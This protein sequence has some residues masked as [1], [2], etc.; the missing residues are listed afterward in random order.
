MKKYIKYITSLLV[1]VLVGLFLFRKGLPIHNIRSVL[2]QARWEWL[3]LALVWQ[4][5]AY[6]AVTTLNKIILQHYGADVPWSKQYVIQLAM[7][8]I[9]AAVPSATISGAVLRIRLLKPHGVSA[10]VATVSTI[11][12]MVLITASIILLAIPVFVVVAVGGLQGRNILSQ[13][14]HLLLT[15]AFSIGVML[16]LW[17]TGRFNRGARWMLA[18]VSRVWD[19]RILPRWRRQLGHWSSQTIINRTRHLGSE[20]VTLIK[21]N[22]YAIG[23][24]LFARSAFEALGLMMCFYALGQ[25]I[26]FF[27][28]LL[29]Y[30]LTIAINALGSVPGG[31][32]LAEVSL[33]VLYTQFGIPPETAVVIALA[34]RLTDYW[35]PRVAGGVAWLWLERVYPNRIVRIQQ[36]S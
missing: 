31:V 5:M 6:G 26:P 28:M 21:T 30:T 36:A 16:I 35:L 2:Q 15:G 24:S 22:P 3:L 11:I 25:H 23:E 34:Y 9:E 29:I 27:T 4:A 13:E 1:V 14:I 33:A 19:N 10:D 18:N 20:A 7:A 12:E 8:F 32:G 17:R